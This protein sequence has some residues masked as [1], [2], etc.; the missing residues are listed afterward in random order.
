MI[1]ARIDSALNTTRLGEAVAIEL[2]VSNEQGL[3]TVETVL[4]IVARAVTA[5]YPVAV[6]NFGTWRPVDHPA[7]TA[8]N[9]QNGRPV[10]IP[11]H[12]GVRFR[13][14][15]RLR[16]LVRAGD[17]TAATIRKHPKTPPSRG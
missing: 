17:P 14:S 2:G 13:I 9:P 15:P 10:P 11:A 7:R 5:G 6:T 4:G 1:K 16:D 3:R 12:Q 8:R